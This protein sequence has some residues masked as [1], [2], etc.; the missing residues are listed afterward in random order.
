MQARFR[1]GW[2]AAGLAAAFPWAAGHG[3]AG[4]AEASDDNVA[5]CP[6]P[7]PYCGDRCVDSVL[8]ETCDDGNRTAGD[9]CDPA[10]HRE[11]GAD[12]FDTPREDVGTPD[13]TTMPDETAMPDETTMPEDTA[14][15]EDTWVPDTSSCPES[16]C[17]LWPQCGCPPGQKCTIDPSSTE[18]TLIK[19]CATAGS[20][21][22]AS[23]CT[24]DDECMAGTACLGLFT[25]AATPTMG[26]CYQFC[27]A[28][29][30]CTG[31]GSYC[32]PLTTTASFPGACSHACNPATGSG[33][34]AGAKCNLYVT[35][36]DDFFT[37]CTSDVGSSR[38]GGYCARESDCAT[39]TFCGAPDVSQC[40]AYCNNPGGICPDGTMCNSFDPPAWIGTTEWGFCY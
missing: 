23:T 40:I 24:A 37:E 8:G 27:A 4:C 39:G 26:M 30:D 22:T 6:R 18:M 11:S 2:L 33:C 38:A 32:L 14:R 20:G 19:T 13:E 28:Q 5:V 10:C 31:A 29:S 25:E 17:R 36:T 15:P 7:R 9:G 34:P 1:S 16:P 12:V 35:P 21:S 3:F